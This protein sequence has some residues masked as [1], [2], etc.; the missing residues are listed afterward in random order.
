MSDLNDLAPTTPGGAV[1]INGQDINDTGV[2]TG[3]AFI[4]G[5]PDYA[6]RSS[7]FRARAWR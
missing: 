1:L 2:I 4:A 6:T 3:R 7:R 5:P